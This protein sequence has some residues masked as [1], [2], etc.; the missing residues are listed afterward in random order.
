MVKVK[1]FLVSNLKFLNFKS[2]P[3]ASEIFFSILLMTRG[4]FI[5]LGN[6]VKNK[7]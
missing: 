2:I 7:Q 5:I 3:D 1:S 6:T 4:E